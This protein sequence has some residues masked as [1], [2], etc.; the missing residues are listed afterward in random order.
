M[1]HIVFSKILVVFLLISQGLVA[2]QAG[3]NWN[4]PLPVDSKVI[5]GELEN[6]MRYYIRKN[7]ATKE[8]V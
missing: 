3:V 2:Q 6:G 5:I 8:R 7:S 4:T 1:K